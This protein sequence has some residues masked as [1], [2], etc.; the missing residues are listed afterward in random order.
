MPCAGPCG[1]GL[2]FTSEGIRLELRGQVGNATEK[3]HEPDAL[4]E[5]AGLNFT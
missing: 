2:T 4:W 5:T 1:P 3:L